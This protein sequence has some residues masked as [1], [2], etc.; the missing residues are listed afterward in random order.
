MLGAFSVGSFAELAPAAA[1]CITCQADLCNAAQV[2]ATVAR[3][4]ISEI[5]VGGTGGKVLVSEV[6]T[7]GG[8]A[9][10][11]GQTIGIDDLAQGAAVG[12]DVVVVISQFTS[13]AR[14]ITAQGVACGFDDTVQVDLATYVAASTATSCDAAIGAL[15][16]EPPCDDTAGCSAAGGGSVWAGLF[17]LGLAVA[18]R[19]RPKASYER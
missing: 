18:G 10:S 4:T 16:L 7:A 14:R 19:R 12:D 5:G 9:T 1:D 8:A 13:T 17:A 6:M 2:D 3:G 11:V 15:H